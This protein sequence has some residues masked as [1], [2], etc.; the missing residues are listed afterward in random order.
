MDDPGQDR[1][2]RT[3]RTRLSGYGSGIKRAVD[4]C[5]WAEQLVQDSLDRTVGTGLPG[6]DSQ[7]RTART[8]QPEME[9]RDNVA[10]TGKPEKTDE[11]VRPG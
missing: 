6:Q 10:G 5:L 4:K 8:G 7:D 1:E 2:E 11:I 9:S 3:E